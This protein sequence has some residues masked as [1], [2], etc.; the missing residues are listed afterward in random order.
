LAVIL[1]GVKIVVFVASACVIST[2][3][4]A[5]AVATAKP[6]IGP[7]TQS[8]FTVRGVGFR[9]F[10]LDTVT[11]DMRDESPSRKTVRAG[12]AGVFRL[13]FPRLNVDKCTGYTIFARG[14]RGSRARYTE[15]PPACGPSG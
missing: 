5:D 14:R 9:P 12:A 7:L 11:V 6:S 8:P 3:A 1:S 10:E 2:V 13:G 4:A 15:P